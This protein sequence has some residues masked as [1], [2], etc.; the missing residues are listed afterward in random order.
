MIFV[1]KNSFVSFLFWAKKFSSRDC[2][3]HNF[4]TPTS[5][6]VLKEKYNSLISPGMTLGKFLVMS[7]IDEKSLQKTQ[8]M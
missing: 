7:W 5:H 2:S 3:F 8:F 6:H 4:L 1:L